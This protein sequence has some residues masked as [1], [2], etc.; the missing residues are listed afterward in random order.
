MKA[1]YTPACMRCRECEARDVGK[2]WAQVI[3]FAAI[4]AKTLPKKGG[5][6]TPGGG[7]RRG[8]FKCKKGSIPGFCAILAPVMMDCAEGDLRQGAGAN[9]RGALFGAGLAG[10]QL[11]LATLTAALVVTGASVI[12][13]NLAILGAYFVFVGCAVFATL[14]EFDGNGDGVVDSKD[15]GRDTNGYGVRDSGEE[16]LDFLGIS[17]FRVQNSRGKI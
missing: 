3:D 9:G 7:I 8:K 11:S 4:D 17:A 16:L 6:A 1:G 15:A 14:A 12:F 2:E 13:G 5:D 10:E